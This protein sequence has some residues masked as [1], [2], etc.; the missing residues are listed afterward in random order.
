MKESVIGESLGEFG[1]D[2]SVLHHLDDDGPE[3]LRYATLVAARHA[4]HPALEVVEAVYEWQG[5]PLIFLVGADALRD[6]GHLR[7]VR[8]LL[9]M[10]GD[11]PYVGVVAPGSL[12]VYRLALDRKSLRQARVDWEDDGAMPRST[13]FARLGN[14]RPDATI[15]RRNWIS[16]V[17]LTLLS[18]STTRLIDDF[19]V[20]HEDAISLVG[21]A[22]FT[23]F[24][25]DR[26]L[27]PRRMSDS[28]TAASL[29]DSREVA[30]ETSGWLDRR[31]NGDLLPLSPDVFATL[32]Q[33]GYGVLGDILRRAPDGQ[34][35]LG[36]EERWANL[37]FAHIPVGVLSEAYELYLRD[38]EPDKQRREGGYFTPMPIVELMVK[39]SFRALER[40]GSSRS[41]KILDPSVGGGVFLLTAFRELVAA[42]W[43]ADGQRPDTDVLRRILYNQ[44][45]GFDINEAALRFAAL[46]LYLL[47]I[48]LDPNTTQV[49]K[50]RFED[51]RGRVLHRVKSEDERKGAALGS[52]GP[53]V[54]DGHAGQYDLVIGNPPWTSSSGLPEWN[55]V[56]DTVARI[57]QSRGIASTSPP[58]P[59]KGLD[60]PFLWRAME[61]A[62]SDGQIAFALHARLLFQQGAGMPQARRAVF[63]ALNV[64]SV[65]NGVELR[66]T[67]IWPGVSAPFCLLFATNRKPGVEAGFRFISPRIE[68]SLNRAGVMRVDA[69]NADVVT[70]QQLVETPDLLKVMFRGSN[71]DLNILRRIRAQEHPTLKAFWF[72]RIGVNRGRMRGSGNGYQR[73]KRSS[74]IRRGEVLRGFD[75]SHLKGLRE[76]TTS[77]FGSI[78]VDSRLLPSFTHDRVHRVR[79]A[80][81]Y[82]GP[83]LLVHKSPRATTGR[84]GVTVSDEDVVFNETFYG[85][86]TR[87]HSR[88]LL[89]AR[90]L[91]LVLGS[92][93]VVW[94]ALVTS[95][96]FGFEREVIEKATLDRMPV[97]DFDLLSAARYRDIASLSDGLQSGRISWGEVDEWVASL[98]G[99]GQRD[100]E[101]IAD[102]LKFNL[103][104]AKNKWSSQAPP[105]S[106]ERRRF[107]QVLQE[108]LKP[109]CERLGSRLSVHEI[110]QM[111][112]SPWYA[113]GLRSQR[114]PVK[115]PVLPNDWTGLLGVADDAAASEVL[116]ADEAG[117][118]L[119]GRLA[120]GRY[121]SGTQARQLAQRIVWSHVDLLKGHA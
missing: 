39:A 41:A 29:F 121:W 25:G 11:T 50:L 60:L 36:W 52:L 45:V 113:I 118:L 87:L 83:L 3:L 47:S 56:R 30:Q 103:P 111:G 46:G 99:L 59:K 70:P 110:P 2:P 106:A 73:L 64:T 100:L 97:P 84:I 98:Y 44:L 5:A 75:A 74:E 28:A 90:Y 104:F 51:L 92:R 14:L 27:L 71:A 19:G 89:L 61:W 21:R 15:T 62:K 117:G 48:E 22:L 72:K 35:F 112:L 66:Q 119:V 85:Y 16:N 20:S 86:S 43:R 102:T 79:S 23:R 81:L 7:Q 95:G 80:E 115:A 53:L 55:L 17:I 63:E 26:R 96:E 109:W 8:R 31:F 18:G 4:R 33:P 68:H 65:I 37:D 108:E 76:V 13:V 34:L 114:G 57:A 69:L 120:Q 10:R 12:D 91:A 77:S 32:P 88:P 67:G 1:A 93:F 9:A 6:R 101:V 54:D 107:C 94:L 58:L 24:L 38:H 78:Y 42:H 82:A 49:D 116:H 105:T 40:S